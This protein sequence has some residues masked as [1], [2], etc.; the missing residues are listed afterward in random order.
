MLII[1]QDGLSFQ[2]MRR[3][4]MEELRN[5]WEIRDCGREKGGANVEELGEC[6]AS[7][8]KL[9]HSCWLVAGTFCDGIIQGMY[10]QKERNCM[11]CKVHEYYHRMTGIYGDEIA[12]QFPDEDVRH[13]AM[14]LDTLKR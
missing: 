1:L 12:K 13:R 4:I 10:A 2:E 9:G 5:C 11:L 3:D 8:D 14:L 7:K 6:P